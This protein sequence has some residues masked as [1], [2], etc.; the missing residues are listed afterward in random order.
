M[1]SREMLGVPPLESFRRI[2][3]VQPHPDDNDLGAGATFAKLA[4]AGAEIRYLTITDG[5]CGS[6]DPAQDPDALA[7]RRKAEQEAAARHL[8][9]ARVDVLGLPD[10]GVPPATDPR[11]LEP[12]IRLVRAWRPEVLV[13]CDPWLAYEAHPD[14]IRVGRAVALAA[15]WSQLP[16]MFQEHARDG[17]VPHEVKAVAF[18]ATAKPNTWVEVR[19]FWDRKMEAVRLHE[20]QFD[21]PEWPTY[22]EFFALQ[23]RERAA[24]GGLGETLAESFK[25]LTPLHLHYFPEA[26]EC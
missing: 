12:V 17:L 14:H 1:R 19:A 16:L 20:S 26:A 25:V 21:R 24:D 7:A 6:Y 2:L 23:A 11:L 8:G 9:I 22:R 10:G 18:Y 5:R 13:T 3:A 15:I 4:Q